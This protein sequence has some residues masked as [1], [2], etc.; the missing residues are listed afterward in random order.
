[1]GFVNYHRDHIQGYAGIAQPLYDLT[2][3]V[4]FQEGHQRA[5]QR[6]KD[7]LVSAPCLSYPQSGKMFI[8]DTDASE[9]S[10]G[11]ELSQLQDGEER[12][13]AYASHVLQPAQKR[14]CV[15]RK[16]LFA[17]VKFCRQFRHFLLGQPFIVRTDHS[18]SGYGVSGTSRV[19]WLVR[20]RN[21]HNST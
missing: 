6:L 4:P 5:F 2:G 8:L 10:I 1:M 16:E 3:K 7:L 18:W 9:V 14:Y 13:I 12:V 21:C 19:N 17:V 15:T 20:W 11:A